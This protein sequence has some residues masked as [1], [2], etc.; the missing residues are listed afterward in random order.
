MSKTRFS[1][2]WLRERGLMIVDGKAV[3][4]V[5]MPLKT[6]YDLLGE[7]EPKA[8]LVNLPK[9]VQAEKTNAAKSRKPQKT[10]RLNNV[11]SR[12]LQILISRFPQNDSQKI[13]PQF[14]VRITPFHAPTL[15]HYTADF[16]VWTRKKN[17]WT[18]CLWEVKD[19]RRRYHSDELTRPKMAA[20]ENPWIAEIW[21]ALWDGKAFTEKLL[22]TNQ[23]NQ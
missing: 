18:C 3:P 13:Q 4:V 19:S 8:L 22:A 15:V 11:E 16:A 21:L 17:R 10:Q 14:R 12:F 6:A 20:T 23:P 9:A 5:K 1:S 7:E 2:E